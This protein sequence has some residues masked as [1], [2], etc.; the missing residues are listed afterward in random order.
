MNMIL[1]SPYLFVNLDIKNQ[2]FTKGLKLLNRINAR[3]WIVDLRLPGDCIMIV[4][5]THSC[6]L[7]IHFIGA[8]WCTIIGTLAT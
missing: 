7:M 6:D 4:Y 5:R 1:K 8:R 3:S 2:R